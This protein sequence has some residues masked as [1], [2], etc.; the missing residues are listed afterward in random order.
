MTNAILPMIHRCLRVLGVAL[1][2]LHL[3]PL[4]THA[5]QLATGQ[6]GE[7]LP[8]IHTIDSN[9]IRLSDVFPDIGSQ[10]DMAIG[11]APQPGQDVVLNARTL[12][13]LATAYGVRWQPTSAADQITL[14][15]VGEVVSVEQIRT[16]LRDA[17][18]AQGVAGDFDL[19][20]DTPPTPLI[21][22]GGTSTDLGVTH[23]DFR[24]TEQRFMATLA[25]A[26]LPDRTIRLGGRLVR[27][28]EVP[29]A[30][31]TIEKGATITSDLLTTLRVAQANLGADTAVRT[32]GL[33][34]QV[35]RRTIAE[36]KPL[37]MNDVETPI[38]ISRGEK[39]A[40]VY[41]LGGMELSAVGRALQDGRVG[42]RLRATNAGSNK[43]IEGTV[44]ANGQVIID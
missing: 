7:S 37:R 19:V 3:S 32:D 28:V 15:R 36:G 20:F 9:I 43:Q 41:R 39:V 24:P 23:L 30:R 6:N 10:R 16:S 34:G 27:Q 44:S 40:L 25:P 42:D 2:T 38:R 5:A 31:V 21:L 18:S 14:R 29:V 4:M 33:I 26:A 22:P 12:L 1:V 13:S 17:I 11:P 8:G 35:A